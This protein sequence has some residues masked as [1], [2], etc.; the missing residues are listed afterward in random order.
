VVVVGAAWVVIDAS[1]V[2]GGGLLVD[3]RGRVTLVPRIST[4][5]VGA[6]GSSLV[7]KMAYAA[8]PVPVTTSSTTTATAARRA[9]PIDRSSSCSADDRGARSGIGAGA[10]GGG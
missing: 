2:E 8:A 5:G 1:V 7:P 10:V 6:A 4:E 3:G 9:G